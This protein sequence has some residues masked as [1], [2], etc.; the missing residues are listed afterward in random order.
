MATLINQLERI[1]ERLT[2]GGNVRSALSDF[3]E[4]VTSQTFQDWLPGADDQRELSQFN[5]VHPNSF[6]KYVLAADPATGSKLVLHS[7]HSGTSFS[8][9][10]V[11]NHRWNFLSAVLQGSVEAHTLDVD[12]SGDLQMYEYT[13]SSPDGGTSFDLTPVG[14]ATLAVI[15]ASTVGVGE[16]YFQHHKFIHRARPAEPRTVTLVLQGPIITP[17]TRV[18]RNDRPGAKTRVAVKR[19]ED[20]TVAEDLSRFRSLLNRGL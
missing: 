18:F 16:V 2:E 3:E 7:W 12:A 13:Y 5:Q 9:A 14:E 8:E 10:E 19:P 17:T 6:N 4:L 15:G 11:H 1:G 20:K